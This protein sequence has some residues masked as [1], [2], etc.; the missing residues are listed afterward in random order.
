[1]RP[2][3]GTLT[4]GNDKT[5]HARRCQ[6]AV[7][8]LDYILQRYFQW[9]EHC[10][11]GTFSARLDPY[12]RLPER[13]SVVKLGIEPKAD[14]YS[15]FD[16]GRISIAPTGTHDDSGPNSLELLDDKMQDL[17]T[18]LEDRRTR[19]MLVMGL[20]TD[21]VPN[22]SPPRLCPTPPQPTIRTAAVQA[23]IS[24]F[25]VRSSR[26][27]SLMPWESPQIHQGNHRHSWAQTASL[28]SLK[29][30]HALLF[31]QLAKQ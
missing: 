26:R 3:T 12:L 22:P 24:A 14:S 28:H 7:S 23:S 13:S 16:G 31:L 9:P 21:Y 15:A 8:N 6:D 29:L 18:L 1:M 10:A 30:A 27:R 2:H 4:A 17:R 20:A 5:D 11:A 25:F 19:R